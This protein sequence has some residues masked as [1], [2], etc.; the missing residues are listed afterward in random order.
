[1]HDDH[2][3]RNAD[4]RITGLYNPKVASPYSYWFICKPVDLEARPLRIFHDW[5]V[6][7][8]L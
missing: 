4:T 8:G 3:I 1:M 5:I 7:A 6:S 2:M